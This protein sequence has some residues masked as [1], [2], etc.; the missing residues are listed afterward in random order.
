[1]MMVNVKQV[2]IFVLEKAAIGTKKK[3]KD[4]K[5][6]LLRYHT[7]LKKRGIFKWI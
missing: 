4:D 5:Q 6:G 3:M 7:S 2:M 1:M